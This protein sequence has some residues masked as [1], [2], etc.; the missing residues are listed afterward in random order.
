MSGGDAKRAGQASAIPIGARG[1]HRIGMFTLPVYTLAP[2]GPTDSPA[3]T[4]K[5]RLSGAFLLATRPER[6][7]LPTFGSVV[8]QDALLLALQSRF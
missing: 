5:S 7:E 8:P 4:K 3:G 1:H 2:D 6:F